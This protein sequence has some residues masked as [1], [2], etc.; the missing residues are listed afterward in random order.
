MTNIGT[1]YGDGSL[2]SAGGGMRAQM[3]RLDMGFE[4]AAPL[5]DDRFES[6]DKS[7]KVNVQVG[8]R[9]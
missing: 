2:A 6:G 3:G 5:T 8:V 4:V 1:G 9:F 7:P